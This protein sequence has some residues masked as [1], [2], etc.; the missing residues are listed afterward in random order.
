MSGAGAGST[1]SIPHF[2]I[3]PM[4]REVLGDSSA[5]AGAMDHL[6]DGQRHASV[7]RR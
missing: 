2:R 7:S 6:S 5:V 3:A 4:A 1:L